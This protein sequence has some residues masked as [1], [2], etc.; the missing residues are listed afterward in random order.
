MY[1][2]NKL[3]GK[4]R[5]GY[6][7]G[8]HQDSDRFVFRKCSDSSCIAFDGSPRIQLAAYSYDYGIAPY[9]GENPEL[10]KPFKT[11]VAPETE[12]VFQLTMDET[13]LST[14]ILRDAN[15]NAEIERQ[16]VQHNNACKDNYYEGLL[17]GLYFGGTC[18]APVEVVAM[19]SRAADT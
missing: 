9:T 1:D 8:N 13:G 7:N 3:W 11:T 19:Y 4:I 2:W 16:T 15:N 14:F 18:T 5:C 17:Q 6:T 12:Y 10:L